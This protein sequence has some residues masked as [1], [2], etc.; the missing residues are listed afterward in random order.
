MLAMDEGNTE[1]S[2]LGQPGSGVNE[3]HLAEAAAIFDA[4]SSSAF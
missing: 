4:M 1:V 2:P 3:H